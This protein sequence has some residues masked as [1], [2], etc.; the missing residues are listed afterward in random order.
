MS[1]V[2]K[3]DLSEFQKEMRALMVQLKN[4]SPLYRDWGEIM[5]NSTMERFRLEEAPNGQRWPE[6]SNA[7]KRARLKRHGN[8]PITILRET[9]DLAGSFHPKA[10]S[11]R[12]AYGSNKVYAAIHHAGG[13]AGRGR[14][15]AIPARTILGLSK[16]D[17]GDFEHQ[18]VLHLKR[19]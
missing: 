13:K 1:V 14:K 5:H 17:R 15:V 19:R 6:L 8:A 18:A 2:I 11:N 3:A 7:T 16:R 12:L 4:K 9:G 10:S